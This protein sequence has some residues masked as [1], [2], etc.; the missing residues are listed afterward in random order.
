MDMGFY[1]DLREP[2][3][4]ADIAAVTLATTSRRS[5]RRTTSR[6]SA[7]NISRGRARS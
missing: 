2:H 6:S 4:T 1:N 5:I 3:I 7:G